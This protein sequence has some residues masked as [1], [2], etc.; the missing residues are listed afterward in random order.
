MSYPRIRLGKDN[1]RDLARW[2]VE[3]DGRTPGD[4]ARILVSLVLFTQCPLMKL[5]TKEAH[6]KRGVT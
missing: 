6:N 2:F 3:K 4:T 1:Q 5:G